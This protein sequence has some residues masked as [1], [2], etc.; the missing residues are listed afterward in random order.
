MKLVRCPQGHNAKKLYVTA[1]G[2]KLTPVGMACARCG[3]REVRMED[4]AGAMNR[5]PRLVERKATPPAA[6]GGVAP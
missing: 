1:H 6:V 3:Y 5:R 4:V 2:R